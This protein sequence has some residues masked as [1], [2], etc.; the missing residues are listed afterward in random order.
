MQSTIGE[1]C[2][3]AGA[4]LVATVPMTLFMA[5]VHQNLPPEQQDPAPPRQITD[6]VTQAA[7]VDDELSEDETACLSVAAHFGFGATAGAAYA[8][9]AHRLNLPPVLGG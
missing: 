6:R 8:P 7:G 1:I 5:A 3:G 9:L 2:Q 4:G